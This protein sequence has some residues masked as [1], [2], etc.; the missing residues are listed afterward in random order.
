M[1]LRIDG[2]EGVARRHPGPARV[3][4]ALHP[5]ASACIPC[6]LGYSSTNLTWN[7]GSPVRFRDRTITFANGAVGENVDVPSASPANYHQV[8]SAPPDMPKLIVDGKLF[9]PPDGGTPLPLVIV[10]AG[11]LGIAPSHLRHAETLSDCGFAVFVLDGFGARAVTST[12]ADQTQFSF[13]ASAYDVLCA[14][15]TL[16]DRP[17]IDADRIGLQGHSRGGSAG[18]TAATRRFADAVVGPDRGLAGVLAA[19]PWSGQQFLNPEVGATK[20]RVL[21]GDADEWC[22]PAQVQAHCQ[23]I[24]LAGGSATMRLIG[25]AQHSFDRDTPIEAIADGVVSPGAPTTYIADDGA[26][27][28]PLAGS[29]DP[30]VVDRDVM[31]Y[32]LKAGY[33]RKGPRIGSRPGEAALFRKEMISFWLGVMAA[34]RAHRAD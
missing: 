14:F 27:I 15:R 25:G 18:L 19:Y 2:F 13:A 10:L 12:V 21:M 29:R 22:S 23:A 4:E 26:M 34:G 9:L 11:S 16:A 6:L 17:E 31:V 5:I 20:I 3:R 28:H 1:L 33:G 7:R 8:I 32:A 24:R 30:A